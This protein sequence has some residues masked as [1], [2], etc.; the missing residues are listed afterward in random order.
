MAVSA[1]KWYAILGLAG[2]DSA[3]QIKRAYRQLARKLHPDR[4][5]GDE[6]QFKVVTAAYHQL[7]EVVAQRA[8]LRAAAANSPR[9]PR[10]RKDVRPAG[11]HPQ[12]NPLAAGHGSRTHSAERADWSSFEKLYRERRKHQRSAQTS[13]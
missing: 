3:D 12:A 10:R 1:K 13:R 8:A 6:E 5:G 7:L 11:T 4:K 9:R 2:D